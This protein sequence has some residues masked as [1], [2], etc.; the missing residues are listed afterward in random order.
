MLYDKKNLYTDATVI[1]TSAATHTALIG[2]VVD[3]GPL[4]TGNSGI[5]NQSLANLWLNIRVTTALVSTAAGTMAITFYTADNS[6]MTSSSAVFTAVPA[7]VASVGYLAGAE[8]QIPL[9]TGTYK[10]YTQL[11]I[12]GATHVITAGAI[13]AVLADVPG[14][15]QAAAQDASIY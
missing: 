10:R 15:Y 8:Y 11:H 4:A 9:P 1:S 5:L 3:H 12:T 14:K 7:A 13:L 2:D 6:A